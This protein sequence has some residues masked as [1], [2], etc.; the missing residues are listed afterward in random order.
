MGI[1]VDEAKRF[2]AKYSL[3]VAWRIRKN[4]SVI[5]K[6]ISPDEKVLYTFIG[7]KSE[8]LLDMF[9][10]AVITLTNRRIIIGRKRLLFGYFLDSVT[11]NMMNDVKVLTRIIWGKVQIDTINELIVLSHIDK[12]AM[13]EI[14]EQLLSYMIKGKQ[15]KIA[16]EV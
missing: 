3:T 1:I 4:A 8:S 15:V 9:S 13:V 5:E 11:P 12:K 10:T 7:Q 14:K 6:Y 16:E 2:K